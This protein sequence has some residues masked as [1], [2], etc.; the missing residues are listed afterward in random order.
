MFLSNLFYTSLTIYIIVYFI[1]WLAVVVN[2]TKF[3][4]KIDLY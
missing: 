4:L 1:V 3:F 2:V